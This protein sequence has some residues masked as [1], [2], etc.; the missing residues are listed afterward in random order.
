MQFVRVTGVLLIAVVALLVEPGSA[1]SAERPN[2]ILMM[3]D[4]MGFSDL[5]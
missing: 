2:I 3:V 1:K 4:D 5:G